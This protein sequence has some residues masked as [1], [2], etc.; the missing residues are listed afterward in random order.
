MHHS[1]F[2]PHHLTASGFTADGM[3]A[4]HMSI[5]Q[6]H[7][8]SHTYETPME[9]ASDC[10]FTEDY[11]SSSYKNGSHAIK[12]MEGTTLGTDMVKLLCEVEFFLR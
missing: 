3:F 8:Q 9:L 4:S 11:W 10:H 1:D 2:R 7:I 5:M 12:E 6:P